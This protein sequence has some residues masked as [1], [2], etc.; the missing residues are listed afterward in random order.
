MEATVC[1]FNMGKAECT[2]KRNTHIPNLICARHLEE[3][4]GLKVRSDY[5]ETPLAYY[6]APWTLAPVPGM[7]FKKDDII[8]PLREFYDK[9][10]RPSQVELPVDQRKYK[11]NPRTD[12]FM[13][14]I[15]TGGRMNKGDRIIYEIIRNLSATNDDIN[16]NPSQDCE[17]DPKP[18]AYIRSKMAISNTFIQKHS[19]MNYVNTIQ[20]IQADK[21]PLSDARLKLSLAYQYFMSKFEYE[22]HIYEGEG[23]S[24]FELARLVPNAAFIHGVG[25]IAITDISDPEP[26]V[27]NGSVKGNV[28][29]KDYT[30]YDE[31]VIEQPKE[32]ISQRAGPH[33][34]ATQNFTRRAFT[35]SCM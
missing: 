14:Q 9:V 31:L 23:N 15:L 22:S 12:A 30:Y 21:F 17:N 5:I 16:L 3:Y 18:I 19:I 34:I 33:R 20:V 6:H 29:P 13:K 11:I 4:F 24:T 8:L 35:A 26:I 32:V 27:V 25:L 2:G 10:Y 7:F 28:I 1:I